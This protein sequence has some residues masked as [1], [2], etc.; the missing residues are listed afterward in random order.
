M[1]T[2]LTRATLRALAFCHVTGRFPRRIHH[3]TW[4]AAYE[5]CGMNFGPVP[6]E[7][8][9]TIEAHPLVRAVRHLEVRGFRVCP[10]YSQKYRWV[11]LR[12]PETGKEAMASCTG[13]WS[14]DYGRDGQSGNITEKES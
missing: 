10:A 12:H 1:T 8:R 3:Q 11:D 4:M 2:K 14:I 13:Y 7:L 6:E 9:G 5:A